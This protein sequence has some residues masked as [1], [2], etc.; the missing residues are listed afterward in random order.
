MVLIVVYVLWDKLFFR[1]NL[2]RKLNAQMNIDTRLAFNLQIPDWEKCM[3]HVEVD[4]SFQLFPLQMFLIYCI[5]LSIKWWE[6]FYINTSW[7][8]KHHLLLNEN[9]LG[10]WKGHQSHAIDTLR[11]WILFVQRTN[12]FI[13]KWNQFEMAQ[14]RKMPFVEVWTHF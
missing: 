9:R 14:A 13:Y 5:V 12:S 3:H 8:R 1:H 4:V 11:I 2:G 10:C 6:Y 7:L